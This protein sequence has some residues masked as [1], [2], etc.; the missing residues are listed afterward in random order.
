MR[1]VTPILASFLACGVAW[2]QKPPVAPPAK[3]ANDSGKYIPKLPEVP[4]GQWGD[5]ILKDAKVQSFDGKD[6][7]AIDFDRLQQHVD[8][9]CHFDKAADI[10]GKPVATIATFRQNMGWPALV[11][12]RQIDIF[13]TPHEEGQM[14]L[15]FILV[16]VTNILGD[17][18]GDIYFK[19]C[20]GINFRVCTVALYG[21]FDWKPA[22][23]IPD[24][25]ADLTVGDKKC[26]FE[27]D[28]YRKMG[29]VDYGGVI[30]QA[31]LD[32]FYKGGVVKGPG[33]H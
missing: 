10:I 20:G 5:G 19:A 32:E 30:A 4:A 15:P 25:G 2:A 16:D 27:V 11:D 3:P 28:G 6:Y 26:I 22:K 1:L 8:A 13:R 23:D 17:L 24:W 31:S 12:G 29:I 7:A 18:R 9:I 21:H 33:G 14:V